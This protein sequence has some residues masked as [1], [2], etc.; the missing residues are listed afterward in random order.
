M[1]ISAHV[2]GT[3]PGC[4]GSFR[5]MAFLF[6]LRLDRCNQFTQFNGFAF[7][8][9]KNVERGPFVFQRRHRSIDDVVHISVIAPRG[10]VAKLVDRLAGVDFSRELMDRQIRAL[11]CPVDREITQ[12]DHS[13]LVK[14][15]V[16]R[17]EKFARD[18][19]GRIRA[20]RFLQAKILGERN[21][22]ANSINGR[23]RRKNKARNICHARGFEQMQCAVNV[24]VVIKLRR[25]D[26]RANTRPGR[27]V[28]NG[29]KLLVVKKIPDT[30]SIPQI[31][32]INGDVARNRR[33]VLAFD[34]G[35]VIVVEVV[36]D[37]HLFTLA[38]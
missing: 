5:M 12:R 31:N 11:T 3:S 23:A 7:A 26:R 15:R 35:I 24:G 9:V 4:S 27:K 8:Q 32:L 25:G 17:A 28:D 34:P 6:Q 29:V 1:E 19:R 36:Q 16:S 18:L 33:D 22:L 30:G 37:C 38:Q 13:D 21:R 10:A 20:D 14:M 2:R